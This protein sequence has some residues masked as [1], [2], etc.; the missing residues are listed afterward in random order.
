[1]GITFGALL[2][3]LEEFSQFEIGRNCPR[4]HDRSES[5]VFVASLPPC[6]RA[7]A[8]LFAAEM[9]RLFNL[10]PYAAPRSK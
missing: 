8:S 4:S 1:M 9:E 2:M 7:E 10:H 6:M 5:Q 3:L